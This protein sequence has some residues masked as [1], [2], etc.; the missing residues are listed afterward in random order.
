VPNC[1]GRPAS[2]LRRAVLTGAFRGSD[3]TPHLRRLLEESRSSIWSGASKRSSEPNMASSTLKML[4]TQ[5]IEMSALP[6]SHLDRST[7]RRP[8]RAQVVAART[9]SLVLGLGLLTACA[10]IPPASNGTLTSYADLAKVQGRRT[11]ASARADSVSLSA[12]RTVRIEPVIFSNDAQSNATPAQ[13]LLIANAMER[14]LCKELSARF[15]IVPETDKADLSIKTFVTRI[16]PTNVNAAALSAMISFAVPA[17]RLPV[18]LGG[19]AA[20][21][22]ALGP[23][24]GQV[25]ALIWSRDAD[26]FSG[27]RVSSIGDAYDLSTQFANDMSK[28]MT[29]VPKPPHGHGGQ[30]VN[31][32]CSIYGK[33]PGFSGRL[34][35]LFGAPP[36]WTDGKRPR[37]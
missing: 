36:E 25:V 17:P 22:E 5:R 13:L 4:K 18:G 34:S 15:E 16:K 37:L 24:G 20:E 33:G 30:P 8:R 6:V 1:S 14:K 11:Q 31:S 9:I 21:A 7:I 35:G 27:K 28:L 10:S 2:K 12:A 29:A 23:E 32:S 3:A 19:F 26:A